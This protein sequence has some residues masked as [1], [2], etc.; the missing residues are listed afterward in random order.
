MISSWSQEAYLKAYWFAA[1]RHRGQTM[2][3]GDISYLLHLS[4]VAMEVTAALAVEPGF[5]GDLAVQCALLH[6]VIEDTPT[7][8]AEV[9]R[10]FDQ[11]VANGVLALSKDKQLTKS[12]QLADS[13]QRIQRQPRE[14]WLVKL[15]D[16][17]TNL[18]APPST[19]SQTKIELYRDE[20]IQIH[21][22]L[23]DGSPLLSNRLL[24][25]IEAY[26]VYCSR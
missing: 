14:I 26:R 1:W 25:K 22:A 2:V 3:G 21:A 11:R 6:D 16:R 12:L 13:L 8:F 18:Q 17:I 4:F 15:A 20:A 5:D 24:A 7:T 23:K 19:W 9:E 10:E